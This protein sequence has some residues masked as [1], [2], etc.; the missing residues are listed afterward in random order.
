MSATATPPLASVARTYAATILTAVRREYPNQPRHQMNG[1]DD[2]ATPSELHPAF[3]GCYDWHSAVEMH[4]AL[5]VLMRLVPGEVPG[6]EIAALF[7][8]HLSAENLRH[9]ADYL[10]AHPGFERPY[11][12]GWSLALADE[13]A[14]HAADDPRAARWTEHLAP[15]ADTV[16]GAFVRWLPRTGYPDRGGMHGNTAFALA[17]ALPYA[18]RLSSAGDGALLAAID[19]AAR[20]WFASDTDYPAAWEPSGADFLSGALTEAVLMSE[21]LEPQPFAEWLAAFLPGL[22]EGAPAAIFEPVAVTDPTDGQGAHLHGL[23]LY[24]AHAFDRLAKRLPSD[25]ARQDVLREASRRHAGASLPAV[26]GSDW[27]VEHWLAAYAVLL[28]G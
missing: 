14:G 7:D 24:R 8:E 3:Y 20:R 27:M 21:L 12:W 5:G 26:S 18:R 17:R 9:E 23:N 4:W 10:A 25:D 19:T 22:R 16:S 11:G 2:L 13:L 1:P 28:L 6:G 15:L